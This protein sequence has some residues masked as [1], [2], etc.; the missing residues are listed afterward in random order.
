MI[1]N[2]ISA[3]ASILGGF[4]NRA[5]QKDAQTQTAYFADKNMRMQE[6]FAQN[7]IRWRVNDA[8]KAGIHPLYA[9]GASVPS[10]TPSSV[11][12]AGDTSLGNSFAAA[13]QDIGRA[14]NSTRTADERA[15]AFTKSMQAIQLESAGVDLEIKKTMLA[16]QIQRNIANATPPSPG[17][18]VP[19]EKKVDER[20]QLFFNGKK[21]DTDPGTSPAK[22]WEDVLGDDITSPGFFPNLYGMTRATLGKMSMTD[23]LRIGAQLN[24]MGLARYQWQTVPKR[25]R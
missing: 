12:F 14:I 1:G 20:P 19:E 23:W 16:S 8:K 25:Y 2:I 18:P 13:G 17:G 9:L 22:T 24:P 6:E 15:D 10:Y 21:L 7:G 4:M 3:G 5:S 11:S